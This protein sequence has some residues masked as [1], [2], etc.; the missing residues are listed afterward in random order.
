MEPGVPKTVTLVNEIAVGC[1]PLVKTAETY[2]PNV[3]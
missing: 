2:E 3:C 1:I